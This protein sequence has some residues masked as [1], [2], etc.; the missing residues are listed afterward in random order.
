MRGVILAGLLAATPALADTPAPSGP[1]R[2]GGD[3]APP[4]SV[5]VIET[6]GEGRHLQSGLRCASDVGGFARTPLTVFDGFGLDVA[7]GY[8]GRGVAIT[9]YFSRGF[10]LDQAYDQAKA[11]VSQ[12]QAA[13]NPV[14]KTEGQVERGGLTFRRAEF[15]LDGGTVR[16]DIWMTDIHGWVLKY[17]VSYMPK[18]ADAVMAELDLLI[19]QVR[20]SAVPHL[21]LCAKSQVPDRPGKAVKAKRSSADDTMTALL[22]G[23]DAMA[24]AEDAAK[25]EAEPPVPITFCVEGPVVRKDLGLLAWRGVTPDGEDA[26]V[27]H[28]S[29]MTVGAPPTLEIALDD[30]GAL[31]RTELTG[32]GGPRWQ[33]T[34]TQDRKVFIFGQVEGRPS[35]AVAAELMESILK[36]KARAIGSYDLDGKTISVT[37]P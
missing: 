30:L 34:L 14:L 15:E 33:A 8:D 6:G 31:V 17:R 22:A 4:Q 29:A 19:A 7:C 20:K 32:K 21:D 28:L 12:S 1:A 23:A 9:Q 35:P 11:A 10:A 18:D 16:S 5:W 37:T 24:A 2:Q 36:G 3:K 13:R 27:D 25:G 26:R